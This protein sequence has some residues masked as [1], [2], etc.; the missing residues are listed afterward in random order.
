MTADEAASLSHLGT[1]SLDMATGISNSEDLPPAMRR[2]MAASFENT[3][4]VMTLAEGGVYTMAV[5]MD[6]VLNERT[7]T[8][9]EIS[10]DGAVLRIGI[11][12]GPN[13]AAEDAEVDYK[14]LTL[15]SADSGTCLMEADGYSVPMVRV[16]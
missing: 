15:V 16:P 3:T 1:W 2:T 4:M 8:W 6:G 14:T 7:G 12:T 5:T 13:A 10:R 11:R 9:T